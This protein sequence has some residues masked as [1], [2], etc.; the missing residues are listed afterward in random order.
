MDDF[1]DF[2]SAVEYLADFNFAA[3]KIIAIDLAGTA[4]RSGQPSIKCR[5]TN[6]VHAHDLH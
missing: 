5:L 2:E 3:H 1:F 6:F 4:G